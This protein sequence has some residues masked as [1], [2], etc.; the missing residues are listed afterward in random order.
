MAQQIENV[1]EWTLVALICGCG[2]WVTFFAFG[3]APHGL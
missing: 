2:L 3:F 1:L